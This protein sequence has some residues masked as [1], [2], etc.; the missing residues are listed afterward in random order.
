MFKALGIRYKPSTAYHTQTDG[1]TEC[2]KQIIESMLRAYLSPLQDDWV[3]WLHLVELVYNTAKNVSTGEIPVA[4]LYAQP[5][6][7]LKWLLDP[8]DVGVN[9]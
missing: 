2:L 6:D 3:K 1:A 7:I 8:K 4:L 5:H 9:P